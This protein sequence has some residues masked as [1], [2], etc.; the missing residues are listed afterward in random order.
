MLRPT[1][2]GG[3]GL[4][5]GFGGRLARPVGACNIWGLGGRPAADA[6]EGRGGARAETFGD[7]RGDDSIF[8]GSALTGD[9]AGGVEG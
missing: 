3:G 5:S 4:T 8:R 2:N 7:D 9:G 1:G 6:A